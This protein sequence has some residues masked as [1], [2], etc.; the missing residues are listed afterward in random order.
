MLNISQF[1][2]ITL[3]TEYASAKEGNNY[4]TASDIAAMLDESLFN[5]SCVRFYDM[6]YRRPTEI[7]DSMKTFG[8]KLDI[9]QATYSVEVCISQGRRKVFIT[10]Q[11]K[12]N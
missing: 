8:I 11:A 10:G 5:P 2:W 3:K 6:V 12:I 9:Y 7:I 4:S 1:E